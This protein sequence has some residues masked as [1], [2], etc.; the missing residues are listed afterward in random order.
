MYHL[1][2]LAQEF[3]HY[4]SDVTLDNPVWKFVRNPFNTDVHSLPDPLQQQ[5]IELKRER[6]TVSSISLN[7]CNSIQ[8]AFICLHLF[9]LQ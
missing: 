2:C 5:A 3:M 9:C 1:D 7:Y 8:I 6:K 4:F